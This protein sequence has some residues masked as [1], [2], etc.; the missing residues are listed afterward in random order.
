MWKVCWQTHSTLRLFCLKIWLLYMV[1]SA[2]SKCEHFYRICHATLHKNVKIPVLKYNCNICFK[3]IV[4]SYSYF[5]KFSY[6]KSYS[7]NYLS[8]YQCYKYRTT[9]NKLPSNKL[10][11]PSKVMLKN[12]MV[13]NNNVTWYVHF[14]YILNF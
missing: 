4:T 12:W 7:Y 10:S 3:D 5:K 13:W 8:M 1:P 14:D 11:S 6:S 9:L 2:V